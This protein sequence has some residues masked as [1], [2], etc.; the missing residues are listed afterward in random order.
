MDSGA[1][2]KSHMCL[3]VCTLWLFPFLWMYIYYLVS[4]FFSDHMPFLGCN[5]C[6]DDLLNGVGS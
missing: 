1:T 5:S 4:V 3:Y 2:I 6:D